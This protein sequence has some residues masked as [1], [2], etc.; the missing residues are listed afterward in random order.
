VK[1][2]RTHGILIDRKSLKRDHVLTEEKLVDIGHQL[3]NS[4]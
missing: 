3:E 2:V 4:P 1:K